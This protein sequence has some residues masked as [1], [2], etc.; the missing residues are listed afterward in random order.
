MAKN[1][2]VEA[3]EGAPR[4]TYVAGAAVGVV[5]LIWAIVSHFI[6]IPEPSKSPIAEPS[7]NI[8]VVGNG[9]VG[10]RDMTG[11]VLT[12]GTPASSSS[13]PSKAAS[14]P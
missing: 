4:W 2:L 6:S 9:S 10:F 12:V 13:A 7:T 5:G 11:G 8:N 14:A 3:K 1:T